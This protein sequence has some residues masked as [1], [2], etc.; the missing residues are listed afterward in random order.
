M[1]PF[2]NAPIVTD[3][4]DIAMLQLDHPGANDP[5]Y[6]TRRGVIAGLAREFRRSGTISDVAYTA[7]ETATWRTAVSRLQA[8]HAE[9]A[10][11]RYLRAAKNLSITPERIPQLSELNRQL[12]SA[13]GFRLAP[14]EGLID[15]K[16]F[17]SDLADGT[18]LCTQ[19][20]R[21]AS[22]PEYTPEPDVIHELVGHAPTFTDPDFAAM[23]RLVGR[24]AKAAE[25]DAL[26]AIKRLY[27]FTVEFGLI[28]EHGE[29]KAFGAGLLSS[30]GELDHCFGPEV[31]RRPFSA[32]AAAATDFDYSA[33]QPTLFV[34][35][36][37]ASLRRE[38]EAF[39]R[40]LG[41]VS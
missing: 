11:G 16:L 10:S 19:Y 18:M 2:M 38:T 3:V 7:E 20:V 22:R 36:S 14:V 27:W 41:L 39:V 4:E 15:G 29:T 30:F 5:T 23:T 33:M 26:E 1:T 31:D 6:R 8:I 13:G 9:K 34:I 21:H 28:R 32:E 37:F 12:T 40:R 35:P 25:G 24:A 17:L